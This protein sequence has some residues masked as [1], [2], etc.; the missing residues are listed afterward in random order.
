MADKK[1]SQLTAKG[2]ALAATDLVEISESDG[3]G[4]YVSKSVTG[5]NIK[6]GLQ[7]T[8]VS[9]TN[10]KTINSTTI[11]GSG[12]LVVS[13]SP[14]GV[15][16]AI[17]FSN[18]SAFSSDASNL[19]FDDTNNRLGVGQNV[20]TARM[21]IKG[22]AATS[23]TTSLLVQN[24]NGTSSLQCTDDL[25]VFNHGKGGQSTNTIFGK[26][27]YQ[28]VTSGTHV[29]N[30]AIGAN[31]L[32]TN[33]SGESNTA[34]GSG[35]LETN[36]SGF[37]NTAVGNFALNA[38]LS[39]NNTA[40]GHG[41]LQST[42]SGGNNTAI[43]SSCL[44]GN[45]TGSENT[46]IGVS[47]SSGNFS[48]SVILGFLATATANNQFVVGSTSINAGTV[49][50]EINTSANVWNVRINGVARKILLA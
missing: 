32:K 19:F 17:Q 12:D 40:F 43:G 14:S 38:A 37:Q 9:G 45:S 4:G 48:G 23:A 46:S 28:G 21:H 27:A 50:A 15:A 26:G 16:G 36:T 34:V 33:T 8:L 3:L 18:G 11:L 2:A 44:S 25:S 49:A 42:S 6:S 35:A 41:A 31:A 29:N 5:A 24:S 20:P 1:I 10:I 47:T 13:A 22:T 39:T 7:A 30:T